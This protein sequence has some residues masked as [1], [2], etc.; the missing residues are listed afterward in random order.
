MARISV[1]VPSR[2]QENPNDDGTHD[3]PNLYLDRAVMSIRRQTVWADHEWE[4]IVGIDRPSRWMEYFWYPLPARFKDGVKVV[5]GKRSQ[6]AAVNAA[7]RKSTGDV[8]AFLED[9]DYWEPQKMEAQ[10][11]QLDT[12]DLITCNQREITPKGDYIR[13]NDFPTPSGWVMK[14]STWEDSGGFDESYRYHMDTEWLGRFNDEG[15]KRLHL[16]EQGG[17]LAG[18][19]WLQNVSA[20][21][22]I[23]AISL[24]KQLVQRTVNPEGGMARIANDPEVAADSNDEHGRMIAEFGDVPW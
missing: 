4:I 12:Y 7:V 16:I 6:S 19:P 21:S 20:K 10:L 22:M 8:L 3:T 24:P 18:R 2:L 11:P 14:R 15:L 23:G 17:T 5:H 9:D 13:V 1:I